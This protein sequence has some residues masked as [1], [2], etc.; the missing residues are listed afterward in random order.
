MT[1][2][3]R[4]LKCRN[5]ATNGQS[6]SSE[7]VGLDFLEKVDCLQIVL[8]ANTAVMTMPMQTTIVRTV[9]ADKR[10]ATIAPL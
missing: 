2:A 1:N 5:F 4:R 6:A 7:M 3:A 8:S 9:P 10:L